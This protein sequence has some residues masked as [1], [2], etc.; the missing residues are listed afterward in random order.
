MP[1]TFDTLA[2]LKAFCVSFKLSGKDAG[3]TETPLKK[4]GR[5]KKNTLET[6]TQRAPKKRGRQKAAA[7]TTGSKQKTTVK[8]TTKPTKTLKTGKRG[9][10][11]LA[12]KSATKKSKTT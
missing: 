10:P 9:R 7:K 3:E 5:P 11:P 8:A 12:K 2:E 6:G 1:I 4:R